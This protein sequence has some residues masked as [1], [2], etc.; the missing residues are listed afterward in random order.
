MLPPPAPTSIRS[1]TG[2]RS[3]RPLLGQDRRRAPL[4][5]GGAVGVE[6]ADRGGLHALAPGPAR[7]PAH[8]VL[9]QRPVDGP[10]G[11]HALVHLPAPPA[12][13]ERLRQLEEEVVQV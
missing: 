6:E 9:V 11:E 7:E 2:T 1:M 4:V 5:V 10:A 13:D 3:G 12:R 8:L